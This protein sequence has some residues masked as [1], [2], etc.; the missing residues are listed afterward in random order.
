MYERLEWNTGN[1][2][3]AGRDRDG[4]EAVE[5]CDR[6]FFE[7]CDIGLAILVRALPGLREDVI[8]GGSTG[9]FGFV[10]AEDGEE[11]VDGGVVAGAGD[12]TTE[13]E[14]V[15]MVAVMLERWEEGGRE[16]G[17]SLEARRTQKDVL[18]TWYIYR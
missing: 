16:A 14:S 7:A 6:R 12:D 3:E 4:M 9:W 13:D 1:R 15:A 17:K 10:E 5:Y 11:D 8:K 2:C 18:C